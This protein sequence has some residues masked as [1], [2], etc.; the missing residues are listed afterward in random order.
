MKIKMLLVCMPLVF[1]M[2]CG[3]DS[4]GTQK[5][6]GLPPIDAAKPI[7]GQQVTTDASCFDL[8]TITAPTNAQIINACT[9][10]DKIFKTGRPQFELPDGGLPPIGTVLG[11]GSA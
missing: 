6:A 3:D 2:A 8:S 10:A 5:D 11:S 7:D 9:D 4:N 1:G